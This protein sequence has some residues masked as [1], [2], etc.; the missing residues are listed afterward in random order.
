[1]GAP[2]QATACCTPPQ[3][4][5]NRALTC[6]VPTE[7]AALHLFYFGHESLVLLLR[8]LQVAVGRRQ[9]G[10]LGFQHVLQVSHCS[11][12]VPAG[13]LQGVHLR[14]ERVL[15]L[16]A[17]VAVLHLR[18]QPC[19]QSRQLCLQLCLLFKCLGRPPIRNGLSENEPLPP[20]ALRGPPK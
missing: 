20:C 14:A 9:A 1:M 3:G 2:H 11:L 19:A 4:L 10:V 6:A 5:T 13:L 12:Q 8:H 17:A 15:L 16:L 7:D 18:L